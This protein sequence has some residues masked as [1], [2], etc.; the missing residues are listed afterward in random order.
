MHTTDINFKWAQHFH[1]SKDKLL[2]MRTSAVVALA[3]IRWVVK[4]YSFPLSLNNF[5]FNFFA[6]F[7][8]IKHPDTA[9]HPAHLHGS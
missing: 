5:L 6:G 2:V 9:L 7:K 4:M 1:R 3:D 8:Q